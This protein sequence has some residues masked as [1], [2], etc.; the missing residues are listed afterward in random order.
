MLAAQV[1]HQIDAIIDGKHHDLEDPDIVRLYTLVSAALT[2]TADDPG[3]SEIVDIFD[4]KLTHAMESGEKGAVD[5]NDQFT[6][7]LDATMENA[8]PVAERILDLLEERGWHGW[9]RPR[10]IP[11]PDA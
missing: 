8:G 4:R 9:T 6:A 3:I 10:R 11:G 7:L 2:W 1:P 5:V